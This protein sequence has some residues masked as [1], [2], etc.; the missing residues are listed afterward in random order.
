MTYLDQ[1]WK[2]DGVGLALSAKTY[3]EHVI[4]KFEDA[5]GRNL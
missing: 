2:E 3:I 5:T 4:P 1:H